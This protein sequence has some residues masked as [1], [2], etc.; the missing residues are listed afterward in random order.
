MT[1]ERYLEETGSASTRTS[2]FPLVDYVPAMLAEDPF[3]QRFL[4]GL[5]H[6][7]GPMIVRVDC[8]AEYL[9]P[10]LTTRPMLDYLGYWISAQIVPDMSDDE[11]RRAVLLARELNALRGTVAGIQAWAHHVGLGD[12]EVEDS[13][14]V[15]LSQQVSDPSTWPAAQP[16][17]V[18]VTLPKAPIDAEEFE[19]VEE[20]LRDLVP[21]GTVIEVKGGP[22]KSPATRKNGAREH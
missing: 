6:V 19:R 5:D 12:I 11:S 3:L 2:P 21:A 13:G 9:D 15:T 4:D 14:S 20:G 8:L 1:V 10:R 18:T 17:K 7:M 16:P 22:A